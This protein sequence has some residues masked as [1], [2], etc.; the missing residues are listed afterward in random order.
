[1]SPSLLRYGNDVVQRNKT[2]IHGAKKSWIDTSSLLVSGYLSRYYLFANAADQPGS[3]DDLPSRSVT[4][5]QIWRP[6][7]VA[8]SPGRPRYTL[9]WE[10]RVLLNT[11]ARHGL[12]YTVSLVKATPMLVREAFIFYV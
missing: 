5:I 6:A 11:A 10:K 2:L 8:Q 7:S 3:E 1:M 9:V 12:L 4:R